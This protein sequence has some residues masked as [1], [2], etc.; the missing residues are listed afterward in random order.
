MVMVI[1]SRRLYRLYRTAVEEKQDLISCEKEQ[2]VFVNGSTGPNL[3]RLGPIRQCSEFRDSAMGGGGLRTWGRSKLSEV[4]NLFSSFCKQKESKFPGKSQSLEQRRRVATS[5]KTKSTRKMDQ[6]AEE[7]QVRERIRK[8]V[9]QVSSMS[10]SLL[11][12]IQDHISFTLQ[13]R[14]K[15]LMCSC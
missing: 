6:T 3:K 2:L 5:S 7:K 1:E 14:L 11:S 10:Q 4:F 8:K 9:N 13:V 12:P 15:I